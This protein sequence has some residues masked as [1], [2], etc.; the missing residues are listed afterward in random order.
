MI[1]TGGGAFDPGERNVYFIASGPGRLASAEQAYDHYLV[2]VNEVGGGVDTERLARWIDQGKTVFLD[3]GIYSLAMDHA[4]A[5]NLTHDQALGMPPSEVDGFPELLGRYVELVRQY[6]DRLW[7]YIEL[8][9]GGRDQKIK[10]RTEL[11]ALGLRPIPVYHPLLDG[12]D[13]F[14]ELCERYD[15]VCFGNVVQADREDR[16][17]LVATAWERHRRYPNVWLHLLGLRPSQLLYAYPINSADAS[18]WLGAIRW[19]DGYREVAAGAGFGGV[20]PEFRYEYGAGSTAES[21]HDKAVA[22]AAYGAM[23]EL[24]N[25][26]NHLALVEGLGVQHY[27]PEVP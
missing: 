9:L 20:P 18:T 8:D 26:R 22:M 17:R 24:R 27:P 10:T 7:G 6:G 14:D 23:V 2:A 11:E 4:R 1:R 12:W 13:Y 5:H 21:G 15:R 16:K 25:W 19:H 3:S